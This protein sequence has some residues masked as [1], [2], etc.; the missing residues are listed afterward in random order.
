MA[1][2]VDLNSY[3][4]VKANADEIYARLTTT[5]PAS[6][7]PPDGWPAGQIATFKTWMDGGCQA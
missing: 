5:D 6:V 7:M 2:T 4:D 3:D 1:G